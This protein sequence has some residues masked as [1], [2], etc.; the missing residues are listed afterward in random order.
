MR[1]KIAVR[2]VE[3][4]EVQKRGSKRSKVIR[5]GSGV[6]SGAIPVLSNRCHG[7]LSTETQDYIYTTQLLSSMPEKSI[8]PKMVKKKR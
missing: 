6:I 5:A 7:S 2:C 8:F 4:P 3:C 1:K